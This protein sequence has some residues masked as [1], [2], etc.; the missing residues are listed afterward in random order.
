L[1][2]TVRHS[3]AAGLRHRSRVSLETPGNASAGSS[4]PATDSLPQP[5][6]WRLLIS[7][8]NWLLTT[9]GTFSSLLLP[10]VSPFQAPSISLPLNRLRS[11]YP[12][13]LLV[14]IFTISMDLAIGSL[15]LYIAPLEP[16]SLRELLPVVRG[17]SCWPAV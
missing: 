8:E 2:R 7:L 5:A 4:R 3:Q 1:L 17:F 11:D 14:L 9:I 10:S 12:L 16:I 15:S 6:P 13:F